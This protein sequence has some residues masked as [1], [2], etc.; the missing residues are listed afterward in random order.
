VFVTRRQFMKQAAGSVTVGLLAPRLLAGEA[1]ASD[2]PAS[3]GRRILVVIQLEGGNDGLNTIVPYTDAQ[4]YKVRPTL[5]FK[6][7]ELVDTAGAS[8]II[9]DQFGLH[10]SM[11][12]IKSLYDQGHVA[13]V[14]G[15]GYPNPSLS[16]FL[17]MDIWHTANLGGL[18]SEGWLGKYADSALAGVAGLPA[19]SV[20]GLLPKTF[21]SQKVVIP[22]I[23]TFQ[24]YDFLTDPA[25]P[26]DSANQLATFE[27]DAGAGSTSPTLASAVDATALSAVEGAIN[28]KT[29]VAGYSSPVQYPANNPLA[30]ELKMLAQILTT[31]TESA[32][33]YCTLGSF[34]H[35]ADQIAHAN[36]KPD[37]LSGQH[38]M[39]LG[40]FSDAVRA[41]Y[42]DM[43][44]HG[45]ADNTLIMQWSEFGRRVNENT[46]FGTDHG[47]AA[48]LF[49]V[50][51][52]V[53]GG[54]IGNQ[55]SIDAID[56]DTAGNMK[57]AV[58][59]RSVYSTI[60]DRWLDVD[61]ASVL[62]DRFE[63]V[64]FLA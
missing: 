30:T 24:L 37:K 44:A 31:M 3:G 16:H 50:G 10:P 34:D 39:L 8:T 52:P 36:G 46:S 2:L 53:K 12:P 7:S 28:V 63:D 51:N 18:G 11:G 49:V 4:Y 56:L 27:K 41:F 20:G 42:D 33:V 6:D 48:P 35:H 54:I 14:N 62:G 29:R 40:W 17:S 22:S 25:Y 26:G 21:F 1:H 47:T 13:I 43:T 57:F 9:S 58:D 15:V 64:G 61:S 38:A 32:L 23:I 55:P 5:A 19:A 59:F 60:L 45:L